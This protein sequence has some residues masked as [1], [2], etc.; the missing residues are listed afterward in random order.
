MRIVLVCIALLIIPSLA[1]A[2]YTFSIEG[3][4]GPVWQGSNTVEIP[5]DGTATRFALTGITGRG[6]VPA[7]RLM[8]TWHI[9]DRH[10]L[11]GLVAPLAISETGS[12]SG[13]TLFAGETF[14]ADEPIEAR[15]QF[16]SYRLTYRYRV[17]DSDR[18]Q[19]V[20]GLTGKVRDAEIRLTQDDRTAFDDD[21][22]VL[23]L[24]HLGARWQVADRWQVR[25]DA[26]ALAGGPGRAVD[27]AATVGYD[28]TSN[29]TLNAGYRMLEGGADVT[30]VY[31]F[32]LLH[33]AIT[34]VHWRF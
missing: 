26:D 27:A 19:G 12:R 20:V 16:N 33:Y 18:F 21:L 1:S 9:S 23:P 5:N 17:L 3:E 34:S 15:Y 6:A 32:A 28:L 30:Q 22:G 4:A 14:A 2:Q 29:W 10:S 24:V 25:L 31:N 13:V 7:G 11:R 8:V